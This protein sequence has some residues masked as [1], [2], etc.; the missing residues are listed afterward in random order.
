MLAVVTIAIVLAVGVV[1]VDVAL[2][3]C[4][5]CTC[6]CADNDDAKSKGIRV[7]ENKTDMILNDGAHLYV[8]IRA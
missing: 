4:S 5:V 2:R 1:L 8:K 7:D 6:G 3:C